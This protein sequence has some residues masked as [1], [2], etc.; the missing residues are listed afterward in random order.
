MNLQSRRNEKK[1]RKK[2][3]QICENVDK[4]NFV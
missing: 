4:T 2:T 1:L 3:M